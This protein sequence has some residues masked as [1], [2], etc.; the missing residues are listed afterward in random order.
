[1]DLPDFL[2]FPMEDGW[3]GYACKMGPII[4]AFAIEDIYEDGD[5]TW[6]KVTALHLDA[7]LPNQSY[8]QV[9]DSDQTSTQMM[10]WRLY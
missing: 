2:V 6:T 9:L 10:R 1:V 7:M 5:A 3:L 4:R 8:H